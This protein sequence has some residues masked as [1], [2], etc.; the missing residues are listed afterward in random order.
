MAQWSR[1]DRTLHAKVVYYGPAYGGKTTNLES[2]HRMTDPRGAGKLVELETADDRTLFF[3]LLPLDLGEILGYQVSIKLYTVPGQVRYEATRQVVLGGAD[4]VVFVADSRPEREE[5]N[6]WSAHNLHLNM[7]A[8]GLDPKRVPVVFQFNKQDL[9][10]SAEPEQVAAWFGLSP[11]QGVAAVATEGRGVL[12]TFKVASG[13]MLQRLVALA[14]ERTR[15]ELDPAGLREHL[16]RAFAPFAARR[17]AG[18]SREADRMPVVLDSSD[19][20]QA[21]VQSNLRLGEQLVNEATRNGR[22]EREID[23]LRR[24]GES[25][26]RVGANFESRTIVDSVLET[27]ADVTEADAASLLQAEPGAPPRLER[28]WRDAADPL[29]G[30]AAGRSKLARILAY[31]RPC[32][33]DDLGRTEPPEAG[34]DSLEPF[35]AVVAAPVAASPRRWLLIYTAQHE[36]FFGSADV[37]FLATVAS[38]LATGLEKSALYDTV[39]SHRDR[40]GELVGSRTR[41]LR[42]AYE[43]VRDHARTKDRFL[44]ALSDEMK[45]PLSAI[46]SA[47]VFLRDYASAV[48]QRAEMV[49]SIADSAAALQGLLDGF[50]RVSGLGDRSTPIELCDVNGEELVRD[51]VQQAGHRNVRCRISGLSGALRLDG[52]RLARALANL[53]DNAAKAS[54]PGERVEL[55]MRRGLMRR[56]AKEHDG[57][58]VSVLDRGP[59]VHEDEREPILGALG[60]AGDPSGSGIG[61]Y[62]ARIIA[63]QHGGRLE[64]RPREGGGNEFRLAVP[65]RRSRPARAE[66]RAVS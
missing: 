14:D 30:N 55:V 16:D 33:I 3:D 57:L 59:G 65:L 6:R 38:H 18:G 11:R 66:Q 17:N 60:Q 35:N 15:A 45:T 53:I 43:E 50:S 9:P 64:H 4:A 31:D 19:V 47:A 1:A 13:A 48:P 36:A 12:E 5:Q 10:E 8:K 56:G 27:V 62:E 42:R 28:S 37:R 49:A 61:L 40:L 58:I 63:A 44:D 25:L 7:R 29:L 26:Q 52:P 41:Q 22:L 24:L 51:A 54:P 46:L 32:L 21:S 34:G 39:A 23:A 2:L 20:L